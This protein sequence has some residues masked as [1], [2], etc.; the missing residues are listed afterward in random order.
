MLL[1]LWSSHY[2]TGIYKTSY[3]DII[4]TL[5]QCETL[6]DPMVSSPVTVDIN[7]L[8]SQELGYI[9]ALF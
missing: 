9:L 1:N 2:E 6:L 4:G 8:I 5:K 7:N 3:R